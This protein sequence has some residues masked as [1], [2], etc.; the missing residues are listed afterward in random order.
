MKTN[1]HVSVVKNLVN[2]YKSTYVL[3]VAGRIGIFD[4]LSKGEM[5]IS[6][7]SDLLGFEERKIEPIMNALVY[8]GLVSKNKEKYI[9]DKYRDVLDPNSPQSQLGYINHALNMADKWRD[10]ESVIK[11]PDTSTSNFKS[12]TGEDYNQTKAFLQAMNTNAIPQANYLINNFDFNGHSFIDIGAGFGTYSIA[13]TQKYP[14]AR[15]TVF[16][17]PIAV[18]IIEENIKTANLLERLTVVPGN[19]KDSLP[20]QKFDDAFLFAV[21]HQ[22]PIEEVEKLLHSVYDLLKEGGKLYLTTF[23]LEDNRIE[24]SFAV[25][26]GVE[27][28]VGSN[29]GRAYSHCEVKEIFQKVGFKSWEYIP[30]IPGPASMYVVEK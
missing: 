23:F 4:V 9:L 22:E 26:F 21:I 7:L 15:G 13:V 10:L 17:L 27:M 12:I 28:L 8:F 5:S 1:N 30:D 2:G 14:S 3:I 18:Q 6:D 20:D 29:M 24:P 19:Y 11:T 16:D 25:L